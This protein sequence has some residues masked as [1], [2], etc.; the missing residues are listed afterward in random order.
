[1]TEVGWT[2]LAA[3]VVQIGSAAGRAPPAE[4][5]VGGAASPGSIGRLASWGRLIK[6]G[7]G[8]DGVC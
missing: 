5:L 4:E 6:V 8:L 3:D 1:M 7:Q 2:V